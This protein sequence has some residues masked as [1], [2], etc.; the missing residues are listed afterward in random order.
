MMPSNCCVRANP[1][2]PR[3]PKKREKRSR[4]YENVS[5]LGTTL[6][7]WEKPRISQIKISMG[8]YVVLS[9]VT[10]TQIRHFRKIC[11]YPA[12]SQDRG[13]YME[14]DSIVIFGETLACKTFGLISCPG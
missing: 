2:N 14:I 3:S 10:T 1:D 7:L 5:Y 11:L 4:H 9:P 13:V 8:M 6:L 12:E